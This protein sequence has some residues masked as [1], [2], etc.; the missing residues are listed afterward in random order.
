MAMQP[1][2]CRP[3]T[4]PPAAST[5]MSVSPRAS[6]TSGTSTSVDTSPQCPPASVP[7]TMT[8]STPASACLITCSRAPASAPTATPASRARDI[9]KSGGTP[10]AFTTIAD[11]MRKGDVEDGTGAGLAHVVA[12]AV[13][14]HLVPE[15]RRVDVVIGEET[16]DVA[17]VLEG[18]PVFEFLAGQPALL[19]VHARGDQQVDAVWFSADAFV[20]PGEFDLEG[21]GGVAGGAEHA[22]TAC[23][24]DAGHDVAAVAE[25][26]QR[27]VDAEQCACFRVHARSPV[28][29]SG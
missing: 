8:T 29:A 11:R 4:M 28:D 17:F 2:I 18:N 1:A 20:D 15:V 25:G 6:S 5:T 23:A 3:V 9:M 14:H 7:A 10:R 21:F 19:A 26:E 13:A 16:L 12:D 27:E 24:A 22:E